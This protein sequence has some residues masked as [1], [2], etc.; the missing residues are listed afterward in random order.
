MQPEQRVRK[1]QRFEE[2]GGRDK[3]IVNH[4]AA[5]VHDIVGWPAVVLQPRSPAMPHVTYLWHS[6]LRGQTLCRPKCHAAL[7][8]AMPVDGQMPMLFA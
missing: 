1:R 5:V 4:L 7:A 2:P 3:P 6:F 8:A